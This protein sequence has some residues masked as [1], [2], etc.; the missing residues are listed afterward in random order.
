MGP[1]PS[2]GFVRPQ[3]S[4][5]K[6]KDIY[7]PP[8]GG[9]DASTGDVVALKIMKRSHTPGFNQ[10]IVR[11][12]VRGGFLDAHVPTIRARYRVQR[13]AMAAA[14]R[15]HLPSEGDLAC[16]WQLPGGGMFFWVEL[17][18]GV[19]AMALLPHAVER[20][21]AFVPGSAFYADHPKH[22]TLRLS[23]VTVSADRIEHGIAL[24]AQALKE[25][26]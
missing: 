3:K 14:L 12:I 26:L 2:F 18:A 5:G 17:P 9:L 4:E 25:H 21:M 8:D 23:F 20:G 1:S 11:E 19:D 13:D 16:H 15:A 6:D 24:L 22:N 7:I 10:R